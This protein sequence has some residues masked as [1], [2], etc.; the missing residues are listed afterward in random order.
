MSPLMPP[1]YNSE[2]PPSSRRRRVLRFMTV[3]VIVAAVGTTTTWWLNRDDNNGM[4]AAG[5]AFAA[6][7]DSRARA[8][9]GVRIRVRV[10]N[11]TEVNGLAKR[12]TAV[13]RDHGFDV[14]E[15]ESGRGKTPRTTTLVQTHTGHSD[16][17]DRI[18]RVLGTGG[19]EVRPDS[20]LRYVDLTVLLGLD[21]KPPA[22]PFRP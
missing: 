22:Q 6:Q 14:V 12:A 19:T 4:T 7:T 10:V 20:L 5:T 17:S 21:W 11:G 9:K 3:L 8:P 15:Y 1:L 18:V 13:L 16:W 2:P